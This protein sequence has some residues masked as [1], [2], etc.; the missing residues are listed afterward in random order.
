MLDTLADLAELA[1]SFDHKLRAENK[2]PKTRA[3][4]GE[5]IAQFLRHLARLNGTGPA[6]VYDLGEAHVVSFVQ[7][8]QGAGRSEATVANRYRG[9]CAFFKYVEDELEGASATQVFVHPMRKLSMPKVHD[10]GVPVL[11]ADVVAA[12]LSTCD[13]SFEGV[14]DQALVLALYDTGAR[15]AELLGLRLADVDLRASTLALTRKGGDAGRVPFGAATARALS[16][17]RRRR[18]EAAH[19]ELSWLWLTKRGRLGDAGLRDMLHRR[20]AQ[21]GV[22]GL[23]PHQF[24]HTWAHEMKKKVNDDTL[25]VLAGWTSREMLDRYGRSAAQERALEAGRRSSIGDAL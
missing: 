9:L 24:R 12:V 6:T 19:A 8:L 22:P 15:R 1:A 3:T 14:R 16:R 20:G 10:K 21:A 11:A 17:Y 13:R 23:H 5:A 2:A 4:Y 25:M 7:A 18:G